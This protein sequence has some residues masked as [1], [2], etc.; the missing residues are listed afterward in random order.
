MSTSTLRNIFIVELL[1]EVVCNLLVEHNMMGITRLR[2][3]RRP[4][5][6]NSKLLI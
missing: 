3:G 4:Q 6:F 2:R 5:I 1:T